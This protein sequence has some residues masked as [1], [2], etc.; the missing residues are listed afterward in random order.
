MAFI[1]TCGTHSTFI[2][3]EQRRRDANP[4]GKLTTIIDFQSLLQGYENITVQCQNC[5]IFYWMP[6]I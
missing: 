3:H 1:F 6:N 4:D 5:G 2:P